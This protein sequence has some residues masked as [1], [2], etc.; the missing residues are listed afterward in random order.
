[1][2]LFTQ[3]NKSWPGDTLHVNWKGV[4]GQEYIREKTQIPYYY[5]NHYYYD[6]CLFYFLVSFV[7]VFA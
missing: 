7:V 4:E 3:L 5:Y 6:H 2:Y 1:M